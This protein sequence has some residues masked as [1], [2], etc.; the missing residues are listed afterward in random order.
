M[1]QKWTIIVK[2]DKSVVKWNMES[3]KTC[4]RIRQNMNI[5]SQN[6]KDINVVKW[7]M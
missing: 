3:N 4:G 2:Q 7:N 5:S 6:L 1:T